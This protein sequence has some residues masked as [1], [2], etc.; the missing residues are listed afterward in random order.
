[1]GGDFICNLAKPHPFNE[2]RFDVLRIGIAVVTV[3]RP[4]L[5]WCLC[6]LCSAAGSRSSSKLGAKG[7]A[8][9]RPWPRSFWENS[10]EIRSW[11]ILNRNSKHQ[12]YT[13]L[14]P[15]KW[16]CR[17][18]S[19]AHDSKLQ[20]SSQSSNESHPDLLTQYFDSLETGN[21]HCSQGDGLQAMLQ[22]RTAIDC[23]KMRIP[24]ADQKRARS[25]SEQ[26]KKIQ[27]SYRIV[28]NSPTD[29]NRE[30]KKHVTRD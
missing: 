18:L 20:R 26:Q 23:G 19:S 16:N 9:L 25:H 1:M 12:I 7:R 29:V 27:E 17:T 15:A 3:F 4:C 6:G 11:K 5:P 8:V 14:A 2:F 10:V 28:Q 22:P 13:S 24:A 21:Y 30:R